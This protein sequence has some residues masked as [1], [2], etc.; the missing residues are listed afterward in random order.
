MLKKS[1]NS[2]R[3]EQIVAWTPTF[4]GKVVEEAGEA[5]INIAYYFFHVALGE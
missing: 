4:E 1:L 2:K 3:N 5:A